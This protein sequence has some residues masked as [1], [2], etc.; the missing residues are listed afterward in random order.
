MLLVCL[1]FSL[2][3]LGHLYKLC[4]RVYSCFAKLQFSTIV[5]VNVFTKLL[6]SAFALL[7]N[8]FLACK[9]LEG[10]VLF[11]C[12]ALKGS[13]MQSVLSTYGLLEETDPLLQ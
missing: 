1:A 6:L 2:S 10:L 3:D 12:L 13:E 11:M 5:S 9:S 7:K 8:F 4:G